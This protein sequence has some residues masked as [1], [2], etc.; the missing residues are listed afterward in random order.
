MDKNERKE[1]EVEGGKR[2]TLE[3]SAGNKGN[4]NMP[5]SP[6]AT[7]VFHKFGSIRRSIRNLQ[8][9][10]QNTAASSPKKNNEEQA[11]SLTGPFTPN[12]RNRKGEEK[13]NSILE[14]GTT[15][16][17]EKADN[18]AA[19][20][21]TEA[22]SSP[23]SVMQINKLIQD[24][25][26]LEALSNLIPLEKELLQDRMS[27][28]NENN[29]SEFKNKAKDIK[30]LYDDLGN[31][32]KSIVENS[33]SIVE[34]NSELLTCVAKIIEQEEIAHNDNPKV[35]DTSDL[36]LIGKPRNWRDLWKETL[37]KSVQE[38][39]TNVNIPA[40][41]ENQAWLS[42]HL[43][44]LRKAIVADLITVKTSVCKCYPKEYNIWDTY[45]EN[46]HKSVSTHLQ[47]IIEKQLDY[48][49][50]HAVLEWVINTYSGEKL[51]G[52]PDLKPEINSGNIAPLLEPST[53][54][55][56]TGDYCTVLQKNMKVWIGNLLQFEK[57][58]WDNMEEPETIQDFYHLPLRI[59]LKTMIEEH[60]NVAGK[61]CK[62]LEA[63]VVCACLEELREFI[64]GFHEAFMKWSTVNEGSPLFMP[65]LIAY[66]NS[67]L[68]LGLDTEKY[69]AKNKPLLEKD[70]DE[71]ID[72]FS[73]SL[74]QKYKQETQVH[75]AKLMTKKWISNSEAF[76]KIINITEDLSQHFKKM[77]Q[78]NYKKFIDGV[79]Y[80][81]VKEYITQIVKKS[82]TCEGTIK[83]KEAAKKI[84]EESNCMKKTFESLGITSSWLFSASF[85]ISEI[86]GLENI[87]EI[88]SK[89]KALCREYPDISE[90]H[91]SAVLYFRGM[92]SGRIKQEIL[93]YFTQLQTDPEITDGRRS[94]AL[95]SEI[96]V[97]N[98]ARC[99]F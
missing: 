69:D 33:L 47:N 43:G 92:R 84:E 67:F 22:V 1:E 2:S 4:G 32:L 8:K 18:L 63:K 30:I 70:L 5:L 17:N 83:R 72:A 77:K 59:D 49:E 50:L 82:I 54:E 68:E 88:K 51:M 27:K 14:I 36:D 48:N 45:V 35:D 29:C 57:E 28:K 60:I 40:K 62:D 56:L 89:L 73:D 78:P 3:R 37:Q 75:F 21:N 80:Y 19:G 99:L 79:H 9:G 11:T 46:Y 87:E 15:D 20:M 97:S 39:I 16:D 31:N 74:L 38:R 81:V 64:P 41:E 12:G 42:I 34:T 71:V 65:Y 61:V 93:R 23:L 13:E 53:L 76:H 86:V 91:I 25:K 52:H 6:L 96:K 94:Q 26:L 44:Y 66:I 55:T 95:F 58:R 7:G 90:R 98:T 10:K 85:L 24:N